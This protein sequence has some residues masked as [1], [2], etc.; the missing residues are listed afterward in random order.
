MPN[1]E[2]GR[3]RLHVLEMLFELVSNNHSIFNPILNKII[4]LVTKVNI[5]NILLQSYPQEF[6]TY[7]EGHLLV[8]FDC[9]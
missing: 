6:A 3:V 5:T 9:S 2:N 8:G 4:S 7:R 1:S